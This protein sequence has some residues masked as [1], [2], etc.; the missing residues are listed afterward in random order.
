MGMLKLAERHGVK[1]LEHY[2]AE[3]IEYTERMVRHEIQTWPDGEYTFTDYMD[4]D[5]VN[6]DPIPIKVKMIVRGDSLTIDFSG[7]SPQVQ[8]GINS[9]LP[10]TFSCCG[11]AVRSVMQADIPNTSGLFRPLHVIAPE[12]SIL[13]PVMPAACSMRGIV[14]FRDRNGIRRARSW[15]R[16]ATPSWKRPDT[17]T[18]PCRKSSWTRRSTRSCPT[19]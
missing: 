11:Y 5:G 2:F 14:G 8:G 18:S 15:R 13:N 19:C 9:P 10:F 3:L 4:D 6:P 17:P 1:A 16:I 7:S 12:G